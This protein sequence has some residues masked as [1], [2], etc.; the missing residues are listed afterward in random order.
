MSWNAS[1]A[2]YKDLDKDQRL[3]QAGV[4]ETQES[5]EQHAH[6]VRLAQD[7]IGSGCV[8]DPNERDFS[9]YLSGHA[10]PKHEPADKY[11]NDTVTITVGQK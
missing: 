2:S 9:I 3:G 1:Y 8:G 6:A 7:L 4:D 11:S 10:N 5:Q